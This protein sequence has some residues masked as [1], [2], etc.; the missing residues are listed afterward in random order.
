MTWWTS[1][2]IYTCIQSTAS[3]S[4]IVSCQDLLSVCRRLL[5]KI[6]TDSQ[7][8]KWILLPLMELNKMPTDLWLLLRS[9]QRPRDSY[10]EMERDLY[11]HR[12]FATTCCSGK[13][14]ENFTHMF[15]LLGWSTLIH[16]LLFKE[17]V[18][19]QIKI[20]NGV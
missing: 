13:Q 19:P 2:R 18:F 10:K 20:C 8:A 15:Y 14:S 3:S 7:S 16:Q 4:M 9:Q 17:I 1:L 6:I 12:C 11:L 5:V